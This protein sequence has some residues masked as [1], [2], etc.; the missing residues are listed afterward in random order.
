MFRRAKRIDFLTGTGR[1]RPR[2]WRPCGPGP[3]REVV[4]ALAPA[5]VTSARRSATAGMIAR[6]AWAGTRG[7]RLE[8]R[9]SCAYFVN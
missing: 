2:N 9:P 4:S 5:P 1:R 8:P 7:W 6:P 3:P